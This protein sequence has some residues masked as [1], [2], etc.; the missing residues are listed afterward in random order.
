MLP[1]S[2]AVLAFKNTMQLAKTRET[3]KNYS[4]PS[5]LSLF[6][7]L[8]RRII[9]LVILQLMHLLHGILRTVIRM[10][11]SLS[12]HSSCLS[13]PHLHVLHIEK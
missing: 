12:C 5:F 6:F 13:P 8:W 2:S 3:V 10:P 9:M 11:A 7:E 4:F 1:S